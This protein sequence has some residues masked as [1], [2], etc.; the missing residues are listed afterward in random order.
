[1]KVLVPQVV[2][3]EL[4]AGSA[5]A[6]A[7][8]QDC[9]C[10]QVV[11]VPDSQRLNSLLLMLDQG[12]ANAIELAATSQLPLIIDE[13]KGRMVAQQLGIRITGF[14]GLLIQAARSQIIDSRQAITLLDQAIANG[15]HLSAILRQQVIAQLSH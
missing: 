3:A 5:Q 1:S 9:P 6:D 14:A 11:E 2:F 12:E 7:L 15:L 8:L 4:C 10:L 13:R